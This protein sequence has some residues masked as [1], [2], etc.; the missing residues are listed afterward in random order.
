MIATIFLQ[1]TAVFF[2]VGLCCSG[3][4]NPEKIFD[5]LNVYQ[6]LYFFVNKV[7]STGVIINPLGALVRSHPVRITVT[8]LRA[9]T[10]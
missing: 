10:Y 3:L 5:L 1:T 2:N 9:R 4:L 8:S 7:R 6:L